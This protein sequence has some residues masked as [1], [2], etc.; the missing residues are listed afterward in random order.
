MT[1][2]DVPPLRTGGA[3]PNVRRRIRVATVSPDG[4]IDESFQAMLARF[5]HSQS[6]MFPDAQI[7]QRVQKR[8]SS[9]VDA[10]PPVVTQTEASG[11]LNPCSV[12]GPV[13]AFG[14]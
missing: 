10:Q 11:V 7:R 2:P 6:H 9:H 4:V 3:V 12:K 1:A 14:N 13:N 8:D 5:V